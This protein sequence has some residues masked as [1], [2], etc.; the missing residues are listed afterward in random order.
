MRIPVIL[1]LAALGCLAA[2]GPA[3]KAA[4]FCAYYYDGSTN[5]GFYTFQQCLASVHGVG[6]SC[7]Q[8]AAYGYRP[9]SAYGP[10]PYG[11]GPADDVVESPR[12]HHHHHHDHRR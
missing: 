3:A 6:G 1:G 2:P 5:C 7:S 8:N 10:G 9:G 4:A 12:R 11:S